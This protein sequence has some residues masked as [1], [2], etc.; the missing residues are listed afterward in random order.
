VERRR[1]DGFNQVNFGQA[2]FGVPKT[3]GQ[4]Q[5]EVRLGR[6]IGG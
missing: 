5:N 6:Q 3:M 4:S 2:V 1:G